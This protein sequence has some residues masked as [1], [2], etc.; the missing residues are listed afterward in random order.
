MI[1]NWSNSILYAFIYIF[2]IFVGK[3]YMNNKPKYELRSTL[4]LWNILLALFSTIGAIRVLPELIFSLKNYGFD[5]SICDNSY[6]KQ[7]KLMKNYKL[8]YK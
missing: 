6:G 4:A 5:Y 8:F 2:V 7:F 3:A 1:S